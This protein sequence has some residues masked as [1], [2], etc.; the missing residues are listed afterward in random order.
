[1]RAAGNSCELRRYS[2]VG[3]LLTR[4]L[5]EQEWAFDPDP[6]ARNDANRAEVAFLAAHGFLGYT[7][8]LLILIF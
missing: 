4:N 7:A 8:C 3:H 5:D 1:M 6:A 2:G